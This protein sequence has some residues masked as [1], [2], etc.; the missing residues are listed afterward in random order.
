MDCRHPDIP[1]LEALY[2]STN[3]NQWTSN[4]N[5]LQNCD[6][7]GECDNNL[8]WKGVTCVNNRVVTLSLTNNNLN[9]FLPEELVQLTNLEKLFLNLNSLNG[10]LPTIYDQFGNLT[11]FVVSG[12][13]LIGSIPSSYCNLSSLT[14]FSVAQNSL[15]ECYDPLLSCLCGIPLIS[16]NPDL[17]I[18]NGNDFP[19]PFSAF[20]ATGDGDCSDN[21]IDLDGN[22]DF[23]SVTGLTT[24]QDFTVTAWFKN[25]PISNGGTE[26][27]IMAFGPSE[28]LEIGIEQGGSTDGE[29][30][31]FDRNRSGGAIALGINVRD[32]MWHHIG[33]TRNGVNGEVFLDGNSIFSYTASNQSVGY[34]PIF[35]VGKYAVNNGGDTEF[36]GQIDDVSIWNRALSL[37]EINELQTC[38]LDGTEPGLEGFWDFNLGTSEKINT[39]ETHIPDRSG[40]GNDLTIQN[41][42][43]NGSTSNLVTSTTGVYNTCNICLDSPI[44]NCAQNQ[45]F[46]FD[47][48]SNQFVLDVTDIDNGSNSAC[49]NGITLS[50]DQN[51]I[52]TTLNLECPEDLGQ[53]SIT[54]YV[55]DDNGLQSSCTTAIEASSS[56]LELNALEDFYNSTNGD[57]W[58]NTV[59]GDRPWFEDCDPCGVV[60]GTPWF[61]IECNIRNRVE[62]LGF[63]GN[64]L[65]GEIPTTIDQLTEL[66]W[67]NLINNSLITGNL[68]SEFC[69]LNIFQFR[70][71]N[72]DLEGTIP[73]CFAAIPDLAVFS[74]GGNNFIGEIPPFNQSSLFDIRVENN[75]L[76]GS[77]PSSFATL[78]ALSVLKVSGNLLSG[79]YDIS[80]FGLCN[81]LN[82]ITNVN[83]NIS[84]G[85][86]FSANW[87][88]F[89]AFGDGQ[90]C[91]PDIVLDA[92]NLVSG[93]Y[94]SSSSITVSGCITA[95]LEITFNAP[96]INFDINYEVKPGAVVVTEMT[97]CQ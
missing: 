70:V 34:G 37:T 47:Q 31:I 50:F 92:T 75:Q 81:N 27:R 32:G 59:A 62:R 56:S 17:L 14:N 21:C 94:S 52:E 46:I 10:Y 80:L 51:F 41:L 18:S 6:P 84:D 82:L 74:A 63:N 54:L 9:G 57:N 42:A 28:R 60:D 77:I 45:S 93:T 71:S 91:D 29:M 7:C 33:V 90:C 95:P 43:M 12:N 22:D 66:S 5:W 87:E 78:P 1:A 96:T 86:N 65:V 8:P 13:D 85:N 53:Q 26:D 64:N 76:S 48:M 39:H 58:N 69:N 38:E 44:A 89:C 35:T 25:N 24:S 20:C 97:G 67:F 2:Y 4:L 30:W 79:C 72:N 55:N 61:G 49:G 23:L 68:P 88:D 15:S 3:G 16:S 11:H 19:I 40:N 83:E 36:F 73:S